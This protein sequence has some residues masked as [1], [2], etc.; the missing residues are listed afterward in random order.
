MTLALGNPYRHGPDVTHAQ[1]L[2]ASRGFLLRRYVDGTYGPVTATAVRRAKAR[3]GYRK[4]AVNGRYGPKLAAYLSGKTKATPAMRIR[5]AARKAQRARHAGTEAAKRARIV[6]WFRWGIAHQSS[7]HYS[8]SSSRMRAIGHAGTLPLSTDCSSFVTLCYNWGGALDPNG[9][10]YDGYGYTGTLLDY[11]KKIPQ[12]LVKPGDLVVYGS[13]PGEH[14]CGVIEGGSDPL[15]ASHGQEG[16]P[17]PYR[18]SV[19]HAAHGNG[20][21]TWLTLPKWS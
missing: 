14:V 12:A 3:L 11:M 7:I 4:A 16:G 17:D 9:R 8:Q 15:L 20:A 2:L 13:Y 21:V 1:N 18:H 10:G 19:E 5:A 6:A